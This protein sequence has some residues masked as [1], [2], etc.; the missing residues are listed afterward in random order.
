MISEYEILFPGVSVQRVG[1]RSSTLSDSLW[2]AISCTQ[3]TNQYLE[4]VTSG[5]E[6]VPRRSAEIRLGRCIHRRPYQSIG[7]L[8]AI[9]LLADL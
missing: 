9:V 4:R 6:C 7:K 8:D 3:L 1:N 2:P 5:E